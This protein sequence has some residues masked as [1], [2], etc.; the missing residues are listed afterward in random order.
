MLT[1]S[2]QWAIIFLQ[3]YLQRSLNSDYHNEYNNDEFWE[4][5]DCVTETWG[6]QMLLE[7]GQEYICSMY[8]CHK[9]LI[10]KPPN[11]CEVKQGRA[12]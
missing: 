3:Q 10:C 5:L 11:I 7:K 12:Q 9:H 6:V 4:L 2:I 8:S 1:L